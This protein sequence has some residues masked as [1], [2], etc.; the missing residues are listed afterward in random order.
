MGH[1]SRAVEAAAAAPAG[2]PPLLDLRAPRPGVLG[3]DRPDRL[4]AL[5]RSALRA[6]ALM[7][8]SAIQLRRRRQA[9]HRGARRRRRLDSVLVLL[10]L[11]VALAVV[12]FTVMQC[13]AAIL[14]P[15]WTR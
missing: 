10:G 13:T 6:L 4:P 12:V 11:A 2:R 1:G 15:W 8:R 9:A 3:I 5:L 14:H 7:G